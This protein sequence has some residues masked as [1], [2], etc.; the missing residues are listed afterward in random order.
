[1]HNILSNKMSAMGQYHTLSALDTVRALGCLHA[2][3]KPGS[4][5]KVPNKLSDHEQDKEAIQANRA[6]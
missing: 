4:S 6:V 2:Y 1:M 5:E 3:C